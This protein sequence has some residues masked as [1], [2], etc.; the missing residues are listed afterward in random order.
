MITKPMDIL[1]QHPVRKSRLQKA[2]FRGAVQSYAE[3]LG[4]S[5]TVEK[6]SFGSHNVVIGDPSK[7][8]FLVTAHYDTCAR[9]PVPNFITP[10]NV[11]LYLGYQLLVTAVMFIPPV[12]LG[13]AAG[14]LLKDP[15]MGYWVGYLMLWVMIVLMVAGP[16]NPTNVNDNTSGVV[17]AL[18][19]AR[20]IPKI[21]RDRVC[22]VLFDLEEAGLI[23][24]AS[25]RKKHKQESDNQ[26]VLN[27]DCVGDG[28]HILFVPT[29]KLKKDA[30][31][32]NPMF[33][34]CGQ[35]GNKFITIRDKGLSVYPSDQA[36]FPYGVGI[37]ALKKGKVG[38]YMD[39]I[40]TSKDTVLEE[41]NV[42]LLRAALITYITCTD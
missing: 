22:F 14:W 10:C 15:F 23:G 28:D 24:S 25:Y 39:R 34:C 16:A 7:V 3:S 40:H 8:K 35:F 20:S 12:I 26:I 33:T 37:C 4:Y 13:Y 42:N 11:W 29:G 32:L 17:T 21:Q 31:R 27:L 5:V 41:T 38:L 30:R 9:M 19:I 1:Q 36:N 18:E 6:G 2:A